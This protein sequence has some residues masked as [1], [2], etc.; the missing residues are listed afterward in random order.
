MSILQKQQ[1][2]NA[3]ETR[4]AQGYSN[5]EMIGE[6]LLPRLNVAK[7]YGTY[8]TFGKEA[9]MVYDTK[10]GRG[11]KAKRINFEYGLQNYAIPYTH[12]LEAPI[13]D[14]EDEQ[15]VGV[16][17]VNLITQNRVVIQNSLSIE[18]EVEI[19]AIVTDVAS[20]GSN[21]AAVSTNWTTTAT[22]DILSDVLDARESVRMKVGVY[23]NTM[24]VS[25]KTHKT[26]QKN[27][28]L[29]ELYKY[30][31]G[32]KEVGFLT[33]GMLATLF[34]VDQYIV[35][36][37]VKSDDANTFS[38]IWGTSFA[39]LLYVGKPSGGVIDPSRVPPSFGY[40]LQL[41]GFP[42]VINYRDES[43]NSTIVKVNEGWLPL[44][45][46]VNGECGWFFEGTLGS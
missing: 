14:E 22:A 15:T 27:Q 42:K 30:T 25:A 13:D 7:R 46:A 23:P 36:K 20:Y 3:I 44:L 10:R 18:R 9:F 17:Q 28:K 26:I 19:A 29:V 34:G 31:T 39:A 1:I 33:E 16:S 43:I 12:A 11:G 32:V 41:N 45:T 40:T 24:V 21:H 8:L 5:A 38:D 37:G 6:L 35:G 4:L 2:V